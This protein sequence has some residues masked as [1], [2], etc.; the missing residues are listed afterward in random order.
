MAFKKLSKQALK[1]SIDDVAKKLLKSCVF[2]CFPA[3]TLIQTQH[4]TKSIEDIQIGDLVWA[5]DEDTDTTAL[6]PVVDIM[7]N[8]TDHTISLYT[9]TEVIETTALHPFYTQDGWKDAS[10]LQTGDQIKTQS[11]EIIEIKDTK[12]NYEPKKVYNF[13]VGNFHT[14]FVGVLAWL[15]HNAGSASQQQL[16]K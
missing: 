5:Y 12:F 2:A 14:Y 7:E 13:T 3:G 6:Q 15:V 4:G 8:E 9:E 11:H 16:K 1:S 10:E